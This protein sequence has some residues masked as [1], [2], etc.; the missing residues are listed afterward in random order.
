MTLNCMNMAVI[1]Q[2]KSQ[3]NPNYF[4]YSTPPHSL[5]Y[6]LLIWRLCSERGYSPMVY[7]Q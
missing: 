2:L 4:S 1:R 5:K 6:G 3:K 7:C